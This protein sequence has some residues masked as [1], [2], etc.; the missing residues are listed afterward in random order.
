MHFYNGPVPGDERPVG[1]GGYNKNKIGHEV[2]NFPDKGGRLYGYF[3]PPKR[4]HAV[5][6]ERID[7]DAVGADKLNHVLV[8]YV[9][10]S[11]DGGPGRCGL[12]SRCRGFAETSCTIAW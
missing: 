8:V 4:T 12:V 5:A 7:H 3:Q 2:Y 6:L 9:A 1:G 10:P 11:P